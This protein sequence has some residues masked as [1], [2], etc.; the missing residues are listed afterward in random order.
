MAPAAAVAVASAVALGAPA[1]WSRAASAAVA[2]AALAAMLLTRSLWEADVRRLVYIA[3]QARG[4]WLDRAV[5][6]T[7]ASAAVT[8][9]AA[10][11]GSRAGDA[12]ALALAV[13]A[14]LCGWAA[15]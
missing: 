8:L 3:S 11:R 14:L 7:M 5:D 4:R 1:R 10:V 13:V 9:A 2:V 12:V 15:G 6:L